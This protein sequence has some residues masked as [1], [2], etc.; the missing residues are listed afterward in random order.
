[1]IVDVL[2]QV[3]SQNSDFDPSQL[4]VLVLVCLWTGLHG[5]H[6]HCR[7]AHCCC[8]TLKQTDSADIEYVSL[9][10]P[11]NGSGIG[12]RVAMIIIRTSHSVSRPPPPQMGC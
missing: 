2:N 12:P 1:M 11:Q 4:E 8:S 10:R 6:Q 5:L 3:K 7:F 9:S